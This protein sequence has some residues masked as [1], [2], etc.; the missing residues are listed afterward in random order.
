MVLSTHAVAGAALAQLIPSNPAL[1]FGLAVASHFLLDMIPHWDYSLSSLGQS[2][3]GSE[4]NKKI[5][6]GP[7]LI[8]DFLK[9]GAD[10]FLGLIL[11][12][13]IFY[14]QSGSAVFALV[15][16]VIGGVLPD[17]LQFIFYRYKPF[18]LRPV[19]YFHLWVHA[20]SN[21]NH[22]PVPGVL[23]QVLIMVIFAL[24]LK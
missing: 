7:A 6:S 12:F 14:P 8:A 23:S 13:L 18:W 11:A 1:G 21:L 9:T 5:K 19:Q 3:G 16:G 20:K 22:R 15:I 4:L 24:V 17:F 10:G 2:V